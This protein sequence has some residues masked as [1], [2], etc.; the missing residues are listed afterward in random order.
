MLAAAQRVLTGDRVG[1]ACRPG[2]GTP[3]LVADTLARLRRQRLELDA[4]RARR[5]PPSTSTAG[6]RT[7]RTS[8]LLHGLALLGVPFAVRTAGP[9]F[10]RG[11]GLERLQE[12]WDYSGRRPPRA[13]WSR[14]RCYGV[15][16]ARGGGAPG[17]RRRACASSSSRR[18]A[19]AA[20]PP[21][22]LAQACVLGLH[23]HADR[24][25]R[26]V[27]AGHRAGPGVRRGGAATAQLGLLSESREPLEAQQLTRLPG[28]AARR[29]TPGRSTSAASCRAPSASPAA[30][31]Q[32]L[33]RLRE[34]LVGVAGDGARRRASTGSWSS[35]SA[36]Q[37]DRA[38]VR[39]AA[40]GLAYSAGRLDD[41]RTAQAV[42]GHLA[43]R[44]TA[45][46]AVGFLRG[47][48]LT[49]REAAWQEPRCS[50]RARR[51]SSRLGRRH[52][53]RAPARAA[54][55]LRRP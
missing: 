37:H 46:E 9:D 25:L 52:L 24:V 2:A 45:P 47:L 28:P 8:R 11:T 27:R 23:D 20:R 16:V 31:A 18:P 43:A 12:H 17:S 51:P 6:P 33:M 15:D 38:L 21:A 53:H 5:S 3:P 4:H 54:A 49:A 13:R 34:L 29:R 41:G 42:A 55:G 36:R 40:A 10:V 30:A 32:A 1:H 50:C 19:R 44:F 35:D 22:L 7:A 48:L 14:R 39:G 26:L